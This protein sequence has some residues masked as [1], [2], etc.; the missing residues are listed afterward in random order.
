[1]ILR[2]PET[3]WWQDAASFVSNGGYYG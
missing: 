2:E 3:T 1:M